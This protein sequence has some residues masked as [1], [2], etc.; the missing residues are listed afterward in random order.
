MGSGTSNLILKTMKIIYCV[1]EQCIA[2]QPR[3]FVDTLVKLLGDNI[4]H[5]ILAVILS[6]MRNLIN[7][8]SI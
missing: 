6:K 8:E 2:R 5:E 1:D 3:L 7:R 4:A